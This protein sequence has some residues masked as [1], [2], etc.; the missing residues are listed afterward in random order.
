MLDLRPKWT[1]S[2]HLALFTLDGKEIPCQEEQPE[3]LLPFNGW[4]RKVSFFADLPQLGAA[5]YEL[6]I[7]EGPPSTSGGVAS[8]DTGSHETRASH[9][10][11]VLQPIAVEDD[12]DSW[13]ADRWSYR[14]IAGRF[15]EIP[16]SSVLVHPGP[17]RRI[18]ESGYAW[19]QSSVTIRTTTS[20]HWPVTDFSLR[21]HWK[22]QRKR[23]K[24]AIPAPFSVGSVLCEVPGGAI[25]RPA[26][27]QEHVHGRWCLLQGSSNGK[28][29]AMAVISSG[30]HGFD[31]TDGELRLSV[32]RG[33]A[34]CHEQG[35]L[36]SDP[37]ARK[38]MDQGIHEFRLLVVR[39][40]PEELLE[41]ISGLADWLSAPPAVYAHL[42]I[43][44][45]LQRNSV[46]DLQTGREEFLRISAPGIRLLACKQS[47]DRKALILRFQETTG[48]SCSTSV[49]FGGQAK[50]LR[51]SFAPHEIKTIRVNRNRRSHEVHMVEES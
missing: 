6:R 28:A 29:T 45:P 27:G 35:Y 36:L 33:A 21:V 17:I 12:G 50:D 30:Q 39:G 9:S 22:E 16:G 13:G 24:L 51:L 4:R 7:V 2:W 23:L 31:I 41:C 15:Q 18:I 44:S 49:S 37:P 5:R 20:P 47:A 8:Q 3:S 10:T 26:D 11:P 46:Q 14:T 48:K 34:Y 43:G 32:L 38:Y 1:G 19:N 40:D 25:T 42:P